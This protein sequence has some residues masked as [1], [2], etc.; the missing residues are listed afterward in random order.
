[1]ATFTVKSKIISP[2]EFLCI[3]NIDFEPLTTGVYINTLLDRDFL[4]TKP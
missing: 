4:G 1:M 3:K 2:G